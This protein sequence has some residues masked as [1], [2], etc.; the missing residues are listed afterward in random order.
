MNLSS[1][2]SHLALG[3]C[4][5]LLCNCSTRKCQIIHWKQGHK[6]GCGPPQIDDSFGAQ[7]GITPLNGLTVDGSDLYNDYP[8]IEGNYQTVVMTS[9]KKLSSKS[10]YSSEAFSDDEFL[11]SSG[12]ESA[13]DSSDSSSSSYS[14]FS[15]PVK[16]LDDF[17]SAVCASVHHKSGSEIE[18]SSNGSHDTLSS[19][20]SHDKAKT[21]VERKVPLFAAKGAE[22]APLNSKLTDSES[23]PNHSSITQSAILVNSTDS[24]TFKER[25]HKIL[26]AN[27]HMM[28]SH[29]LS[30]EAICS[31]RKSRNEMLSLRSL[32]GVAQTVYTSSTTS[33]NESGPPYS[34]KSH[35]VQLIKS[36]S[37]MS[38][39][40]AY[41]EQA[42]PAGH[43]KSDYAS[44]KEDDPPKAPVRFHHD[45]GS[46]LS[47]IKTSVQRV[48]Q[49]LKLSKFSKQHTSSFDN[50]SSKRPKV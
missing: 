16:P 25:E 46:R 7:I 30:D 3:I 19:N 4:L 26:D 43:F 23:C 42:S 10:S 50:D 20:V 41:V 49:Q 36:K 13:S 27:S 33:I 22:Y 24:T 47:D 14:V 29:K 44:R 11:D 17:S 37:L 34:S 48:A 1:D 32:S 8:Y 5:F 40:P 6:Y 39:S 12:A 31:E 21:A 9:S 35:S 2:Q 38:V 15:G 18:S 28:V 45:A